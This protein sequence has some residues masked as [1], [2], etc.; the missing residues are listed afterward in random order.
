MDIFSQVVQPSQID[1]PS[2]AVADPIFQTSVYAFHSVKQVDAI[3]TGL[4][5]GYTYTRGKNPNVEALG[6]L[7]ARLEGAE[8]AVVTA[9]GTASVLAALLALSP[10]PASIY[11]AREIYGG[12][13]GLCRR[14]LEPLGY[15]VQWVDGHDPGACD[16]VFAN[17][18]GVLV[19]ESLSNP[20][21]RV[22]PLDTLIPTAH[23]RGIKVLVDNTFATPFHVTPF[24][25]GAD[26]VVHSATKFIGGHSDV[27]LGVIVGS[28]QITH[29]AQD[30]VDMAGF[31]P[32]PFAAWLALRGARTLAL[33]MERQ[34]DNAFKLARALETC[35]AISA[36]YYPG[37]P[38]HP[39]YEIAQKLFVRGFGA[40]VSMRLR[41]GFDAVERMVQRLQWVRM[42]PSLGDVTTTVSHP[43]V[44]SHRELSREERAWVGI[45]EGV[46]RIS[47]GIE[48]IEDIIADF[49]QA[50]EAIS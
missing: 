20:L 29:A 48:S 16:A 27:V 12:T 32:D 2:N 49:R 17:G 26:V 1:V 43:V 8:G 13:V 38:S 11:L 50:L 42:V 19:V 40:I 15:R 44:A 4:E 10:E 22:S 24:K 30:I 18:P 31:T 25:W 23:A 9:S 37:L 46:V 41:Q 5:T 7:M 34:S 21:G 33:R 35:S 45:D 36:V 14:V 3:L 6:Q 47:V 39:D 28:E